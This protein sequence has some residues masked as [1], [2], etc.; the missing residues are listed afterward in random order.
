MSKRAQCGDD[1][2]VYTIP[3]LQRHDGIVQPG[4]SDRKSRWWALEDAARTSSPLVGL[5]N[6]RP[7]PGQRERRQHQ[8]GE[9]E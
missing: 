6:P 1:E 5:G 4:S 3:D 9:H 2:I 8:A 7:Q